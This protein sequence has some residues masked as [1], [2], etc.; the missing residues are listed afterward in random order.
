MLSSGVPAQASAIPMVCSRCGSEIPV[1]AN[2]CPR[3]NASRLRTTAAGVQ[4]PPPTVPP[5]NARPGFGDE[6]TIFPDSAP[7]E[8]SSLADAQ[9]MFPIA[10]TGYQ[11]AT[12]PHTLPAGGAGG[13][14]GGGVPRPPPG[15]A[16]TDQ[17]PL[18]PGS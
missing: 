12:G 4:T 1:S 6:L 7:P 9:T 16:S 5:S 17:G 18:E 11:V 15:A 14:D 8:E 10:A 3:C 13:G 2:S